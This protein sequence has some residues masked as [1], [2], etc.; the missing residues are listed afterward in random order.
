MA[1]KPVTS[2]VGVVEAGNRADSLRLLAK[3][4]AGAIETAEVQ[5]VAALSRQLVDVLR[6]L[7]ELPVAQEGS[8]VDD[9]AAARAARR[10]AAKNPGRAAGS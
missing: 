7:D 10:Q 6:E 4:L 8:P 2:L 3:V 1:K 5:N 9:L